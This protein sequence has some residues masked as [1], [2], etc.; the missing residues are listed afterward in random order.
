MATT[1]SIDVAMA[2]LP[3]NG[4]FTR[5]YGRGIEISCPVLVKNPDDFGCR[6]RPHFAQSGQSF[7]PHTSLKVHR[8][9]PEGIG[10]CIS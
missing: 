3:R 2:V 10:M 7:V 5:E 8:R 6:V 1:T 9:V 4:R